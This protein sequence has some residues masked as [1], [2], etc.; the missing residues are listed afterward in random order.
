MITYLTETLGGLVM[1]V[2]KSEN[3]YM[4]WSESRGYF[5]VNKKSEATK[6]LTRSSAE[7]VKKTLK[8][9]DW[10]DLSVQPD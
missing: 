9:K 6:F 7:E 2:V 8:L 3:Q 4:S 10:Q 1:F 5:M